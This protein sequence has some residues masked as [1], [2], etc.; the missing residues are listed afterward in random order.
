MF[1]LVALAMA[2]AL[3]AQEAHLRD[4]VRKDLTRALDL[5][6]RPADPEDAELTEQVPKALQRREYD[7]VFQPIYSLQ[8]GQID[9]IEALTRFRLQPYRSPDR[10]FSAADA[11]GLGTELQLA[12]LESA[13]TAARAAPSNV[14]VALNVSAATLADPGLPAVLAGHARQVI[15]ELTEHDV[16]GNYA[17]LQERLKPLRES[18]VQIAVDDAGA[19]AASFRHIVQ[20]RPDM[21]K[22]DAS[23]TQGVRDS[24]VLQT[25]G[26]SFVSFAHD[27]GSLLVV[28]GIENHDDL[29]QWATL[30]ADCAQGYLLARPASIG[31]LRLAG[32]TG[33]TATGIPTQRRR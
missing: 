26:R 20:L 11:V 4:Q 28:E 19:G 17:F 5:E 22:L 10:W 6:P 13:L 23:L 9:A 32:T 14:A 16:I 7:I 29:T 25:L 12:V 1:A 8:D 24:Q 21:I 31:S 2:A 33:T 18:G 27:T 3:T 15:L 30:G